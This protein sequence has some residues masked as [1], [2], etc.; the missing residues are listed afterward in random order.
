MDETAKIAVEKS[1][2][3][4]AECDTL[5]TKR[6][7]K[8][9]EL[10][11]YVLLW[12]VLSRAPNSGGIIGCDEEHCAGES[13]RQMLQSVEYQRPRWEYVS[14]ENCV[15]VRKLVQSGGYNLSLAFGLA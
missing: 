6:S 13:D 10:E 9:A 14:P 15:R 11:N 8:K 12:D 1:G 7:D 5:P 2:S 3:V 4:A